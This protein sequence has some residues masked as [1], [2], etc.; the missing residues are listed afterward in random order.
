MAYLILAKKFMALVRFTRLYYPGCK[1]SV[2]EITYM[3]LEVTY[4]DIE[5][6]QLIA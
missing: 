2:P 4:E 1:N 6:G 3:N 5:A